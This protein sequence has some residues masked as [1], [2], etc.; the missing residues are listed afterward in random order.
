MPDM[1]YEEK[2]AVLEPGD[3]LLLISDGL[4]EAHSPTGRM[5]GTQPLRELVLN[6]DGCKPRLV[7]CALGRLAEFT[8]Q[9][10]EQEDDITMV[11]LHRDQIGK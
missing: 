11:V 1:T 4:V 6:E 3:T 10:W 9:T 2:E 7:E 8:G 5:F